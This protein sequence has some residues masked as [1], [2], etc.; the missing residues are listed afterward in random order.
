MMSRVLSVVQA[1]CAL[2]AKA[3]PSATEVASALYDIAILSPLQIKLPLPTSQDVKDRATDILESKEHSAKLSADHTSTL[4]N[5][6]RD[7]DATASYLLGSAIS[8][9]KAEPDQDTEQLLLLDDEDLELGKL[10]SYSTKGYF[11]KISRTHSKTEC[12]LRCGLTYLEAAMKSNVK[13]AARELMRIHGELS[14]LYQKQ[15][16]QYID[17]Q[18]LPDSRN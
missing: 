9:R 8:R 4:R 14:K 2:R 7:G 3:R 10:R 6:A 1:C 18:S 15:A 12:H 17:M 13:A 5:L 16:L 11:L